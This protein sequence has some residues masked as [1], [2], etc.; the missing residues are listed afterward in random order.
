MGRQAVW[1]FM[2]AALVG[3]AFFVVRGAG[4][5]E[6][7][8]T[9]DL[10]KASE[11][12]VVVDNTLDRKGRVTSWLKGDAGQAGRLGELG[13]VCLPDR[14]ILDGWLQRHASHPGRD[15]WKKTLAAG[16]VEQVVFLR[17][18]DGALVPTCETEVMLGRSFALHPDHAAFRAELDALLAPPAAP[19]ASPAPAAPAPTATE[20]A[21]TG[22]APAAPAPVRSSGCL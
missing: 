3:A 6:Q 17:V 4:A 18:R 19:L 5:G 13:G 8:S 2:R 14:A 16:H 10:E 21:P 1:G 20:T 12:I 11:A 7:L 22:T 9:A 15:T